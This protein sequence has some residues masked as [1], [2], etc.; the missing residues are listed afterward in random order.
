[1]ARFVP[2]A[3]RASVASDLFGDRAALAFLEIDAPILREAA[4]DVRDF[5]VAVSAPDA[6]QIERTGDAVAKARCWNW[7]AQETELPQGLKW[8][9][10]PV[11]A[12]HVVGQCRPAPLA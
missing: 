12:R 9:V 2:E 8:Q 4:Q 11:E 7:S 5:G 1:M 6:A 3:E 10:A